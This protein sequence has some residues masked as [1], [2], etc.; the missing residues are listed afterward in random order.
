MGDVDTKLI[1]TDTEGDAPRETPRAVPQ[2]VVLACNAAGPFGLFCFSAYLLVYSGVSEPA[3]GSTQEVASDTGVGLLSL[4]PDLPAAPRE[5]WGVLS[6]P[7]G[8]PAV[9]L[10]ATYGCT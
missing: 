7:C 1:Q 10:G 8:V 6:G 3:S 2:Q 5:A 9:H 4:N